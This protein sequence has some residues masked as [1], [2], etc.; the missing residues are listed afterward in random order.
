[1]NRNNL[2]V[3]IRLVCFVLSDTIH[4]KG[5][6]HSWAPL[7][8]WKN[9][10]KYTKKEGWNEKDRNAQLLEGK[11]RLH[12]SGMSSGFQRQNKNLCAL[13]GRA[14]GAGCF[15]RCNGC[16]AP[17]DDAGME[18]KIERLLQ[19]RPDAAHMGVC[20]RRK[21]DGTRCPTIQ[22]VADRLAAEGVVLVDGTH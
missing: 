10:R 18:E 7:F 16:D 19:L 2:S 8:V 15:F 17:Q 9:K 12:R 11:L 6:P 20:T 22:K 14:A 3:G 21:A 5:G 13:W 1:M 4:I